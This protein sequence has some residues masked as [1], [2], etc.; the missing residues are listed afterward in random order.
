MLEREYKDALADLL[1]APERVPAE[2]RAH[3]EECAECGAEVKALQGTLLALDGWEGVEPSPFFDARMAARMRR[4]REEQPAGWLERM[5]ARLMYGTN[6]H[7]RPLAA[8]ALTLLLLVGGGTF[9]GLKS[10]ES[11]T[12]VAASATVRDLQSLD[13]NAQVFQ[14][15][16]ALDQGDSGDASVQNS[17]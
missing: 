1:L 2:V 15:M 6:L 11:T 4:A 16:N 17:N 14:A 10:T 5:R 13:E 12:P 3:V 7:M 8:G 9:A